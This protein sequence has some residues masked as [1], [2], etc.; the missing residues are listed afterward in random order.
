MVSTSV[1]PTQIQNFLTLSSNELISPGSQ[2]AQFFK[3]TKHDLPHILHNIKQ[4]RESDKR[5][6]SEMQQTF[7]DIQKHLGF[8]KSSFE[9]L[10]IQIDPIARKYAKTESSSQTNICIQL[11]N[12]EASRRNILNSIEID[13]SIKVIAEKFLNV[14]DSEHRCALEDA[15]TKLT[16]YHSQ[17]NTLVEQNREKIVSTGFTSEDDERKIVAS[18]CPELLL[19]TRRLQKSLNYLI[20]HSLSLQESKVSLFEKL[21]GENCSV[22]DIRKINTQNKMKLDDHETDLEHGI[23]D[24][25]EISGCSLVKIRVSDNKKAEHMTS[26]SAG[27]IKAGI[28]HKKP[29]HPHIRQLWPKRYVVI[30]SN[31]LFIYRSEKQALKEK[32]PDKNIEEFDLMVT[33]AKQDHDSTTFEI[34]SPTK[35][36]RFQVPEK[37]METAAH[38]THSINSANTE[39]TKSY[40]NSDENKIADNTS[41]KFTNSAKLPTNIKKMEVVCNKIS[42]KNRTCFDCGA[43]DP[44]W[45]SINLGIVV[46]IECS[47]QHRKLGSDVSRIK[48]LNLDIFSSFELLLPLSI[49][50]TSLNSELSFDHDLKISAKYIRE[51]YQPNN[52]SPGRFKKEQLNELLLIA[53]HTRNPCKL[54]ALCLCYKTEIIKN[55]ILIRLLVDFLCSWNAQKTSLF[56]SSCV[57]V[58]LQQ[59]MISCSKTQAVVLESCDRDCQH[60]LLWYN[61]STEFIGVDKLNSDLTSSVLVYP[62]NFE[63]DF[64]EEFGAHDSEQDNNETLGN[65]Q[66]TRGEAEVLSFENFSQEHSSSINRSNHHRSASNLP[67]KDKPSKNQN[68]L[69]NTSIPAL[70]IMSKPYLWIAR[71]LYDC[72]AENPDELVFLKNELILVQEREDDSWLTGCILHQPHRVGFFPEC[73]TTKVEQI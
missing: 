40:L 14:Q 72:K 43:R 4:E 56:Y 16:R 47:G 24:A 65:L 67:E 27:L 12:W 3:Y 32:S 70:P 45:M 53:L 5:C 57:A 46:C 50:N 69:L 36:L 9:D 29:K 48:S 54:L 8:L 30:K 7:Q 52:Y 62:P 25:V 10:F 33:C 17:V 35:T 41:P 34:I 18:N 60:A 13:D 39:I 68:S 64:N 23:T 1:N 55:K 49:G 11:Q 20:N 38:W 73:Y 22:S 71:A 21:I 2:N 63:I 59:K 42:A 19:D 28:L 66:I 37:S 61:F 51:N 44:E 31:K 15:K 6:F 58:I 26:N